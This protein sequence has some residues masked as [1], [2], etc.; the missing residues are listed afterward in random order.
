MDFIKINTTKLESIVNN[1]E[2]EIDRA[3]TNLNGIKTW[4][5][6]HQKSCMS[7]WQ[8]QEKYFKAHPDAEYAEFYQTYSA[9][10]R[11]VNLYNGK[12]TAMV[13]DAETYQT[14]L[15]N[16][17]TALQNKLNSIINAIDN[18]EN[19][20]VEDI[21]DSPVELKED[22][23]DYAEMMGYA[24]SNKDL[25]D[26]DPST[27]GGDGPTGHGQT[28]SDTEEDTDPNTGGGGPTGHEQTTS[29]TTDPE[30]DT[31]PQTTTP[32]Q[33]QTDTDPDED[34]EGDT[35]P[36]TISGEGESDTDP[37]TDT[38]PQ[39]GPTSTPGQEE[40]DEH[41]TDPEGETD[42]TTIPGQGDD[43]G[44]LT[45]PSTQPGGDS[46]T[47]ADIIGLSSE[48]VGGLTGGDI[49][50]TGAEGGENLDWGLAGGAAALMLG[51]AGGGLGGD[52]DESYLSNLAQ[53]LD[54]DRTLA[55]MG[56]DVFDHPDY[57]DGQDA[58]NLGLGVD[59]SGE[60]GM[61]GAEGSSIFGEDGGENGEVTAFGLNPS[62][63][64]DDSEGRGGSGGTAG[65]AGSLGALA[66]AAALGGVAAGGVMA[67]DESSGGMF[68]GGAGIGPDGKYM[69]SKKSLNDVLFGPPIDGDDEEEKKKQS[70]REKIAMLATAS[71]TTAALGTFGL[72]NGGVIG[73]T[74][75]TIAALMFAVSLLYF[76]MVKDQKNKRRDEIAAMQKTTAQGKKSFFGGTNLAATTQ[77]TPANQEVD[78]ILF[79]MV[80]LSTSGFILKTYD[81]IDWLLFLILLILFV[82][83]IVAYI[84]LKKKMGE[85]DK[86]EPMKK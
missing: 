72:A 3:T 41:N 61:G 2:T 81:V 16:A 37:E 36:S 86:K 68:D 39:S 73:P 15:G 5:S 13:S 67:Y 47:G 77:A 46:P 45:D 48:T 10:V 20:T 82:L 50:G 27:G 35:D 22:F 34:P 4:C 70:L 66:G 49:S 29:V 7:E 79:G 54:G 12:L 43:D 78:W 18:F 52:D 42:P 33:E 57:G 63:D 60:T 83:I 44:Q 30:T 21:E 64:L 31:D 56:I 6:S 51:L 14:S 55:N 53:G 24:S 9:Q 32:G 75:F 80:L 74:W 62:A 17:K 84:I 19:A 69:E 28:D 40:D 1:I 25:E 38:D 65:V 76:N 58:M 26:T 71:S 23:G 8:A 85:D 59:G 11:S